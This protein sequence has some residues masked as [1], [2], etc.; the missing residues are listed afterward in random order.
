M[1][2]ARPL[3]TYSL[4]Q[5]PHRFVDDAFFAINHPRPLPALARDGAAGHIT[6][7]NLHGPGGDCELGVDS[8]AVQLQFQAIGHHLYAFSE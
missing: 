5:A 4:M 2:A 1:P 8:N 3:I 7:G 6:R